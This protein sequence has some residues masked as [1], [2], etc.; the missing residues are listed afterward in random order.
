MDPLE[1]LGTRAF[2]VWR[3][4]GGLHYVKFPWSSFVR[5][6]LKRAFRFWLFAAIRQRLP[7][8]NPWAPRWEPE[9]RIRG[10]RSQYYPG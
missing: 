5:T 3:R 2:E 4:A 8:P 7:P 9:R 1:T 10:P 6:L